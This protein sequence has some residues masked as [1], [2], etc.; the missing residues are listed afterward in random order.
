MYRW[1]TTTTSMMV[2]MVMAM[3]PTKNSPMKA[4]APSLCPEGKGALINP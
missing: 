3:L 2:R 4:Y 1:R